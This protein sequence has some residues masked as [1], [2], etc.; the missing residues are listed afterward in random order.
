MLERSA[1]YGYFRE[2]MKTLLNGTLVEFENLE[3]IKPE[4]TQDVT[5]LFKDVLIQERACKYGVDKCKSDASAQYKEWMTNYDEASPDNATI[6]PNV[7]SIVYCYG[8]A[9]GGEEEWNHAWRHY[10]KTNLASEKT[11]MLSAMACTEEVWLLS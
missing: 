9:N 5:Q 2:Y 7:N 4:Y 8:V 3:D 11:A 10:T 6:S 1:G